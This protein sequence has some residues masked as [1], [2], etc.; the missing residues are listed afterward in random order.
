[1]I[2]VLTTQ[3]F[4]RWLRKLKDTQARLRILAR[5]DRLA[6]GNIGDMKCVGSDIFELRLA[7][8]PGYRIYLA[9][10]GDRLVLL[11]C[12]GDK[13]SQTDDIARARALAAEWKEGEEQND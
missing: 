13:S 9:R 4:D 8:G 10:R 1:M 11:L 3:D 7:F 12:G 2:E 6:A 5:L